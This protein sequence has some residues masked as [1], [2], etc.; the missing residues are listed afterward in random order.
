MLALVIGKFMVKQALAVAYLLAAL[1]VPAS[2]QSYPNRPIRL[3]RG[4]SAGRGG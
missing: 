1:T 4:I 2:A 3:M